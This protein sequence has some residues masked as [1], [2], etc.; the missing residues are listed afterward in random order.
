MYPF[1]GREDF[2]DSVKNWIDGEDEVSQLSLLPSLS[3]LPPN[4]S[5]LIV[6]RDLSPRRVRC[7][8]PE[9]GGAA[10]AQR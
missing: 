9:L 2:L 6:A 1:V 4:L 3:L 5:R 8:S 7:F 10:K